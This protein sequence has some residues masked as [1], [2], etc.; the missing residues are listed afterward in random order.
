MVLFHATEVAILQD[1]LEEF[2]YLAKSLGFTC[3]EV[4][5]GTIDLSPEVRE[6][7]IARAGDMGF[8]VL[9]EVGKKVDDRNPTV[10]VMAE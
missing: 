2:L 8:K 1:K 9:T 4:S 10:P 6:K 7:A 5:D 3:I